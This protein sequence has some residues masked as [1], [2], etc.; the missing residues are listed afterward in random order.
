MCSVIHHSMSFVIRI[1]VSLRVHLCG[2]DTVWNKHDEN[3]VHLCRYGHGDPSGAACGDFGTDSAEF[4]S[5]CH[6]AIIRKT[7]TRMGSH[8]KWTPTERIRIPVSVSVS[9]KW[10]LTFITVH[11][12]LS[13]SHN[14]IICHKNDF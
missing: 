8:I 6:T 13:K 11:K 4:L 10:T 3:I 12:S 5:G 2:T 14:P 7:Y 9:H 1:R